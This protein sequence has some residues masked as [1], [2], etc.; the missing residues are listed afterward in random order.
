MV[1]EFKSIDVCNNNQYMLGLSLIED[2]E[3]IQIFFIEM[4][5]SD[6]FKCITVF[7]NAIKM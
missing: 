1:L 6:M 4:G 5:I 7:M 3:N 2:L